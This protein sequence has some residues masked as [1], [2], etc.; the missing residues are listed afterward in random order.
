MG[1]GLYMDEHVPKAI[2]IGLRIRGVDVVTAQEDGA[3]TLPDEKLLDRA[4][5]L[6]RVLVSFDNDFLMEVD[7]RQREGIKHGGVIHIKM[8]KMTVGEVVT[9]LEVIGKVGEKE[10]VENQVTYLPL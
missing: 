7:R 5:E 9:D 4:T 6:G 10:D 2:T 8:L 3:A 1:I